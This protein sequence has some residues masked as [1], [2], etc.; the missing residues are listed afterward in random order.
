MNTANAHWRDVPHTDDDDRPPHP[1]DRAD[2]G[3]E[4]HRDGQHEG[5]HDAKQDDEI[6]FIPFTNYTS[7]ANTPPSVEDT[8]LGDRFLCREGGMLFVGPSGIGKSS[9]SVQQDIL[10][11]LG[12]EAFGIKPARPLKIVTIQAENDPGDLHEMA[13]G[14]MDALDLGDEDRAVVAENCV[15]ITHKATTGSTFLKQIVSNALRQHQPDVMRLDPFMAYIG[16]DVSDAKETASFLRNGLNPMLEEHRCGLI[17][18]HHTPKVVNRDTSQWRPSD[19]MYSG[20]GS[21]DVTNW[22]RA[23]LVIDPTHDP[24]VFKF[25]GAKR[26][27]RLQW[28]DADGEPEIERFYSHAPGSAMFWTASSDEEVTRMESKKPKTGGNAPSAATPED[29]MALVPLEGCISRDEILDAA[30]SREPKIGVVKCK[31]LINVL[32]EQDRL[33]VWIVKRPNVRPS[34]PLS[35]H[36]Q[37]LFAD[38]QTEASS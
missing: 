14:V 35:R 11:A 37:D 24:R 25:I 7:L 33:H 21:A 32:I 3:H 38:P 8:L 15:V 10:W 20:G 5:H 9:A 19:W 12:R 27:R 36:P 22:A 18:N 34:R 30:S 26:G 4:P 29:V 28:A 17:L 31:S 13:A 16:A 1:A 2:D 6:P 23:I